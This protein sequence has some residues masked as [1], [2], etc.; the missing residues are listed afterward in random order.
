MSVTGFLENFGLDHKICGKKASS[1]ASK[2][3]LHGSKQ[4]QILIYVFHQV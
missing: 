4:E 2:E 1:S 3:G